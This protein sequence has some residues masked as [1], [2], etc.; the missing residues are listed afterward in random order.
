[1]HPA[2]DTPEL[3]ALAPDWANRV[4]D[5]HLVS[6]DTSLRT[7]VQRSGVVPLGFRALRDL[8]RADLASA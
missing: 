5:H 2:A 1:V 6:H 8:M 3:R 7:M 4:D